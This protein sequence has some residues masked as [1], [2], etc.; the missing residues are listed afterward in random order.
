MNYLKLEK[1]MVIGI[2][3]DEKSVVDILEEKVKKYI[4]NAK[5]VRF[6]NG[7]SLLNGFASLDILLLDIQMP[8]INGMEVSRKIRR[9]NKIDCFD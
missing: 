4:P 3:D 8:D 2:C 1:F 5:V 7:E 6:L 9:T